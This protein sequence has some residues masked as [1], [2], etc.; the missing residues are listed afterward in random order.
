M[1]FGKVLRWGPEAA[2]QKS[3]ELLEALTLIDTPAIMGNPSVRDHVKDKILNGLGGNYLETAS[4][5]IHILSSPRDLWKD[6]YL[7]STEVMSIDPGFNED[8][9]HPISVLPKLKLELRQLDAKAHFIDGVEGFEPVNIADMTDGNVRSLLKDPELP[10]QIELEQFKATAIPFNLL[11]QDTKRQIY[12]HQL[13]ETVQQTRSKDHKVAAD[14]RNRQATLQSDRPTV[15]VPGDFIHSTSPNALSSLLQDGN[16]A[17][18]SRKTESAEDRFPFNVDVSVVKEAQATPVETIRGLIS[19]GYGRM[20]IVYDRES[21]WMRSSTVT[22]DSGS[23]HGLTLGGVPSTEISAI[24]VKR[25]TALEVIEASRAI[26][27]NGFYIPLYDGS[28]QLLLSPQSYDDLRTSYNIDQT[29]ISTVIDNSLALDRQLG[30]NDGSEYLWPQEEGFERHYVKFG[31]QRGQNNEAISGID[32]VWTEF[33]ADELYRRAGVAVPKTKMVQVE[34]RVGKASRWLDEPADASSANIVGIAPAAEV[35][36]REGGFVMDAWLG[37]WDIVRNPANILEVDGVSYRVDNGN[38][39]DIRAQGDKKPDQLWSDVVA[40]LESGQGVDELAHGM[41]HMY[42]QLTIQGFAQQVGRLAT[43][44]SDSAIDEMVDSIRRSAADRDSLKRTLKARRDY[45][46]SH[47]DRI[48]TEL[49]QAAGSHQVL[50]VA[51]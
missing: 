36:T 19:A 7:F 6:L 50:G 47:R 51:A 10:S 11:N 28:G 32:H 40:E 33:L 12:A 13:F 22:M 17:G 4:K 24:V 29:T 5:L 41:R 37:N 34:G 25:P 49:S 42:P 44:F 30:S 27:E 48:I 46:V 38:A 18:E 21:A 14:G 9:P 1:V 15:L 20:S 2:S 31:G 45:I 3:R 23:L 43:G 35:T 26:A 39:L 16:I 8:N